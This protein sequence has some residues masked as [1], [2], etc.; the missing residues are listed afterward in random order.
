MSTKFDLKIE[1]DVLLAP[2]GHIN[3]HILSVEVLQKGDGSDP[4]D[5]PQRTMKF[6]IENS[7]MVIR[8][9]DT[10]IGA[11]LR[12]E[13]AVK[14]NLEEETTNLPWHILIY[15]HKGSVY[16]QASED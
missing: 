7:R 6:Y 14:I 2:S 11:R 9:V 16:I 3:N 12:D 10:R 15:H 8:E 1:D 4:S 13:P 5:G